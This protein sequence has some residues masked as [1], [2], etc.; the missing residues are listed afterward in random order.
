VLGNNWSVYSQTL[1]HQAVMFLQ[2]F[3]DAQK[4]WRSSRREA[5][6][7]E[8]GCSPRSGRFKRDRGCALCLA[9]SRVGDTGALVD[10]G[11]WSVS[12]AVTVIVSKAF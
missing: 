2:P 6:A 9:M 10:S 3:E 1:V 8:I 5:A 12:A 7:A 4:S 11:R